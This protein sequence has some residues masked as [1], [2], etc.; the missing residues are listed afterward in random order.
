MPHYTAI[1]TLLAIAFYFFLATRAPH[2]LS[3]EDR[4]LP[5]LRPAAPV[6][7]SKFGYRTSLVGHSHRFGRV[8]PISRLPDIR[9]EKVSGLVGKGH[10]QTHASHRE[11][12]RSDHEVSPV[13][14][15][16]AD[17]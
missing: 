9:L 13:Q 7:H 8:S 14:A 16:N 3:S 2:R 10:R 4:T 1:V 5:N 17:R 11:H 6:H 15:S 12:S